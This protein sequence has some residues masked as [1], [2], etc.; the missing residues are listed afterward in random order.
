M[1]KSVEIAPEA[2]ESAEKLQAFVVA[3]GGKVSLSD[4]ILRACNSVRMGYESMV[5]KA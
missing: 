3:H 2:I 4:V 5:T 1:A